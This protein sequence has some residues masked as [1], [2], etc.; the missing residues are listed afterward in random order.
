VLYRDAE[1]AK[2]AFAHDADYTRPVGFADRE[3]FAFW[4]Y[5]P[6][7]SRPFRALNV[8]LQIKS[9]GTNGLAFAIERN[10][11][12]AKYFEQLVHADEDFEMLAPVELSI[13]CFRYAPKDFTGDLDY[14]NERAMIELQRRGSSYVSNA[15]V[16]GRFALRGCVLNF[17]TEES[18]MLRLLDD[19]RDAALAVLG[20]RT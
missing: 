15:S 1:D 4:D 7:L 3:A 19:V 20:Q 16:G 12:C 17:R 11:R 2:R 9:A 6:E 8:W 18:D 14:L 5:G 10:I 13:F